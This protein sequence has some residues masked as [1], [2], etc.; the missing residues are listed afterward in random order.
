[1]GGSQP[2]S[3]GGELQSLNGERAE[4]GLSIRATLVPHISWISEISIVTKTFLLLFVLD[5]ASRTFPALFSFLT[6]G[7]SLSC[8]SLLFFALS[9]GMKGK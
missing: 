8:N 2:G 7:L 3:S 4:G 6:P 5:P 1:M 9:L